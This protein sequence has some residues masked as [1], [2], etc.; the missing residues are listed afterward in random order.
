MMFMLISGHF[1]I[2]VDN[3]LDKTWSMKHK[4]NNVHVCE[5]MTKCYAQHVKDRRMSWRRLQVS[6]I[7]KAG[8]L[9]HEGSTVGCV[10]VAD[11][12]S[13]PA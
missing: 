1:A 7:P 6:A 3:S 4:E 12:A 9:P 2:A 5:L 11:E 8:R 13:D 10:Q